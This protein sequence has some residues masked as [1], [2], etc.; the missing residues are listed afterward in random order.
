MYKLGQRLG[1]GCNCNGYRVIGLDIVI[2][3]YRV[4]YRDIG[5]FGYRAI[6]PRSRQARLTQS[7]TSCERHLRRGGTCQDI[8]LSG[9]RDIGLLGSWAL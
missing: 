9:A 2:L 5:L 8:G 3:G 7:G 4:G 6:G 1:R